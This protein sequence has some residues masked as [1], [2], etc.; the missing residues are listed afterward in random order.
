MVRVQPGGTDDAAVAAIISTIVRHLQREHPRPTCKEP[1][2][3]DAHPKHHACVRASFEIEPDL[4]NELS[5]GLFATPGK[6]QAW[7]RFSNA[8]KVRHDLDRDAR[9]MAIKVM[10]VSGSEVG[11]QDFLLVT[12]KVFFAKDPSDFVDFPAA[13]AG[14]RSSMELTSRVFGFF[15]GLK[16]FRFKWSGHWALQRSLNWTTNPLVRTYFSQTPYRFGHSTAKFRARP[17][18]R[19]KPQQWIQ[20]WLRLL[21]YLPLSSLLRLEFRNWRNVLQQ[22]L[23][24][25]LQSQPAVFSCAGMACR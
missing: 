16:P 15:F 11:T 21:V 25:H 22:A 23:L 5:Q 10:G 24:R 2:L 3:R 4:P 13:V 9:G 17:Q 18:Q 19:G 7:V 1:A 8:F 12:H 20:L 14:T 6:Y